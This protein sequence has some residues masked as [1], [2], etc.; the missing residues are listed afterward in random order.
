MKVR[1]NK[2]AEIFSWRNGEFE[3]GIEV[4]AEAEAETAAGRRVETRKQKIEKVV[5]RERL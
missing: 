4:E 2:K 1:V 5:S 3:V